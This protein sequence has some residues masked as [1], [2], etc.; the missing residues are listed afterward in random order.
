LAGASHHPTIRF[1]AVTRQE[2]QPLVLD[3]WALDGPD[4]KL[5]SPDPA[6]V[7]L[8]PGRSFYYAEQPELG[9]RT[10]YRLTVL[11]RTPDNLVVATENVT[12]SAWQL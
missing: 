10:V 1:W 2:W 5:R 9:G 7:A 8:V 12:R 3:A 4:G 11:D 6:A